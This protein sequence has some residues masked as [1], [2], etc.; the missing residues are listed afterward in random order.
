MPLLVRSERLE[1]DTTERLPLSHPIRHKADMGEDSKHPITTP[2][3]TTVLTVILA[4]IGVFTPFFT[5]LV[6]AQFF[7]AVAEVVIVWIYWEEA[8]ATFGSKSGYA[9]LALPA[10][11][12][13]LIGFMAI[14][15]TS[16]V[17]SRSSLP[18]PITISEVKDA[19]NSALSGQPQAPPPT[20][21]QTPS[22]PNYRVIVEQ[23]TYLPDRS[24]APKSEGQHPAIRSVND[25]DI[26]EP[27]LRRAKRSQVGSEAL[28]N[29]SGH[30]K[31]NE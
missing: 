7:A 22:G 14:G 5:S 6:A 30:A 29:T 27:V 25:P 31:V 12:M 28:K 1:I 11:S 20:P 24:A 18:P 15:A 19:V 3:G 8:R 16:I 10:I 23:P 4:V 2:K 9:R 13:V 26:L 17:D 21:I